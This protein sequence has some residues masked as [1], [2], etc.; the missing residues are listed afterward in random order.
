MMITQEV[1][2]LAKF[3][4]T[5]PESMDVC[6]RLLDENPKAL[7]YAGGTDILVKYRNKAISPE[8]LVDIKNINSLNNG[9]Q[10]DK[11]GNLR[12]SPLMTHREI[13]DTPVI[14]ENFP[15]LADACRA[16]GSP[17]IRN[18]GTIGGNICNGSPSADTLPPLYVT[19]ARLHLRSSNNKRIVPVS[20]FFSGPQ[21]TNL[22][23]GEILESIEIPAIDGDY[24]GI[25]FRSIR[26]NAVDIA[27]VT[28]AVLWHRD[29]S[30][31]TG[32]R[33]RIALGAVA[34]VVVRAEKAEV[35]L[36]SEAFCDE[37]VI[38]KAAVTALQDVSPIDD[39]RTTCDYRKNMVYVL[40]K[41]AI[42]EL[43]CRE[44]VK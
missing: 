19:E 25:Y 44:G 29:K 3:N 16:V 12:I 13:A 20:E 26:R 15:F 2:G 10:F 36:N 27:N 14:Q 1:Y 39:I 35:Y 18:R 4:Y 43:L 28:C 34:P 22:K 38:E 6:C 9:I 17:Q 8:V 42:T 24:D 40:V 33:F 37:N 32:K 23:P 11:D 30:T 21:K 7:V 5:A 41:R 31:G